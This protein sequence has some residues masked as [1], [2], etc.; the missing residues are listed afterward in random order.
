MY[1]V[2]AIDD[3]KDT[4]MLLDF[5]L[6]SAGYQVI[7]ADSGERGLELLA[8]NNVDLI[9]LDM[10]MAGMSGLDTLAKIKVQSDT[11]QIPVIMLS[12]SD[13]ED[14]IV[15]ALELGADDYVT[16]PYIAKVL[17]ARIRTSLRLMEKTQELERLAKTD[18]LT[19][20]NNRGSFDALTAKAIS[21][22]R[23]FSQVL[24]LAMFD[25][26]KFKGINDT[27]GHEAGDKVL[28]DF[29]KSLLLSF[30]EYDIIGRIGGEEFAVCM[31][32]TPI[33]QALSA[34]ERLR[35]HVEQHITKVGENHSVSLSVT[36]SGG[37]ASA[38]GDDIDLNQLFRKADLGLY[39]AKNS[40]RNAI[41]DASSIDASTL[42]DHDMDNIPTS[43]E[44]AEPYPGIDVS[45]G[46]S[47]VLGDQ[48][49]FE[50]I[51][52]MFYQDHHQDQEKIA[53]A[54]SMGDILLAKHLSHTLKGVASSIGAIELS[55]SVQELDEAINQQNNQLYDVLYEEVAST[56][57]RVITGIKNSLGDR[58][59]S[60]DTN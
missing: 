15:A 23:R 54:L 20:I 18:F 38:L 26:D 49:L 29:A 1:T 36:V 42:D 24:T 60:A 43:E 28:I 48:T 16:K 33:E 50:E 32:N 7:T 11:A 10:Y 35:K 3:A 41:I 25:I 53:Q 5:D 31:P 51:L 12:A 46:I 47:N 58:I 9:L 30:R 17:L 40:G 8:K 37:V 39:Q 6:S 4:I 55:E 22:C 57:N 59:V 34:C 13:D 52:L 44:V 56:L 14:E 2:L 19:G 21:Q 27:Y 45:I